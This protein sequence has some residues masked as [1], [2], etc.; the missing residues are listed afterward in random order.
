MIN[1]LS[2][3]I[4]FTTPK[5]LTPFSA[6]HEHIPFAF[7]IVDLLRPQVIVELGTAHGDSYCAF[8]Q[9]VKEL[10]LKTRCYAVDTW[11]GDPHTG[12]YGPEVL[13]DLRAHHDPLYGTFSQ[14]VQSTFDEALERFPNGSIDL[15]HIDGYHVY[16][17]VKH[18]FQMWLPKLSTRGVVLLHDTNVKERGFGVKQLW[19]EVKTQYPSFEFFH[20]CGLGVLAIGKEQPKSLQEFLGSAPKEADQLRSLFSVL[21]HRLT[22][23]VR[24][25]RLE[26]HLRQQE[27]YI[28]A[29]LKQRQQNCRV[30]SIIP[31]QLCKEDR[32]S[33]GNAKPE[34]LTRV[35]QRSVRIPDQ[36]LVSIV[37]P[38]YNQ[39]ELTRQCLEAIERTVQEVTYEIIVVDNGSSDLTPNE[40]RK[41]AS[42]GR[43][44]AIF[45][46]SN[47]GFGAACNQ[48]ARAARGKYLIFLNNDTIPQPGWLEALVTLAE[49]RVKAGAVGAKLVYPDGRLQEAGGIVFS[50][51]SGWNYGR[52]EDPNDPRFNFVRQVDYCSAAC[53]LVR[54]DL[55]HE[56]GGF[57]T[58]FEPAYYEDT[59]LCFAIRAAGF[60]VYYQPK[61]Q[62]IHIEGATAG[63]D[64]STGFK[65]FQVIN[66]HK[67]VDK[68]RDV[69]QR[70]YPPDRR[71]VR[72]AS[73]RAPGKR[74][75][76]VDAFLPLF[77]RASG[78]RRLFEILKIFVAQGHAVTFIARNGLNQE[79][80]A[81]ELRRLGVEVYST[82]PDKLRAL[83]YSV[84]APPINLERLLV[85]SRYDLAWLSFYYIA[86]QYLPD[87][88]RFSPTTRICIDTGDIHFIREQRQA[89][90]YQ[91]KTLFRK[92]AETRLREID[93]YRQ[94]DAV[95]TVT[96]E[97]RKYLLAELPEARI[98]VVPNIHEVQDDAPPFEQRHGLLFVGNFRHTPNV[99]AVLFF[100][101]E[102]L[103][104]VRRKI[105]EVTFTVVGDAPPPEIQELIKDGI[106]V[107]GY[108]P[109]VLP[110]LRA[111]RVAVAPLR[112]GAGLKGKIGEAL[113][114]GTPVVTTSIGS[115][116]MHFKSEQEVLLVADDPED[117]AAATIRLYSDKAL[118]QRLSHN[119]RAYVKEHYAPEV[120]A[121]RIEAILNSDFDYH[122]Q[123]N[124][125]QPSAQTMPNV[126]VS[127]GFTRRGPFLSVIVPVWKEP[128]ITHR[129]MEAVIRHT[130]KPY[131]IIIIDNASD[132]ET[133]SVIKSV[134]RE[135]S[136]IRIIRNYSN[137][138][139]PLACN[140]GL[141]A[142]SG[143][144]IVVMNNDVV[145]TPHWASRM[146]AAFAIDPSI[147]IVG[148][149]TNYCAGVQIVPECSYDESLLDSWAE[150]WYLRHAG[151]LRPTNRLIGFL[152]MMKREVVEKIG[153]FDPLF[154]I[155]NYEDDDYCIRAQL[156]GYKLV[157]ADDV[158][159]HHYGSRSFK[160]QPDAYVKL[161]QTNKM[162]FAGKWEVDFTG[163]SYRPDQVV[164]R[165]A[166]G[167]DRN[168]LYI[169]L[170][171]NEIFSPHVEPLDVG[172]AASFKILCVPDPS[173]HE[174]SWLRLVRDYLKAFRPDEGVGLVVRVEPS[175]RDWFVKV[176]SAIQE[177]AIKEGIDLDRNDL[178]VEARNIPS[179]QRG[180]VYRAANIFVALPGIRKQALV[181]EAQACGLQIVE[182]SDLAHL[183]PCL[184]V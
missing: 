122:E 5:R 134:A 94:A 180:R 69:L 36:P 184:Q 42:E 64:L 144:Y 167:V 7:F 12:F 25:R 8:C 154:G 172:C 138:G 73:N 54:A 59:D 3:P 38:V 82:D 147:G 18:D 127:R 125:E 119:G 146:M 170:D 6:W 179:N 140:Q 162:L 101:R 17:A 40:L 72:L 152:W 182:P 35:S 159:V 27:G 181:R 133:K 103:P 149:R 160:K 120:V 171:F 15:L 31:G 111:H 158:F 121:K 86:E 80:Y 96:E 169:P 93:I 141:A 44:R 60:E 65:R 75:L 150:Q 39:V 132:S 19:D 10:S 97:D 178:V 52:G 16:E 50:D 163:N 102:I 137:L 100:V 51:G 45:N 43:L 57:D 26:E 166:G 183:R 108:V 157:I 71:W 112:Y 151:T 165:F 177:M 139:Y 131:E 175:S 148:P 77:D 107:T 53:L 109:D 142:A 104:R 11:R 33:G 145:V 130:R 95:I 67:F 92:A 24:C 9:A 55:F 126:P 155:G 37:I 68:W 124:A 114:A 32:T 118:W 1:P 128:V 168:T 21:G 173:D 89:E 58:R 83:G 74:I 2:H 34:A 48:G 153:G 84:S 85:E 99:D 70:Q 176:V 105:P 78:S 56:L 161:L 4:I 20:G 135:D 76:V 113:A 49:E 41:W 23:L 47:V 117:F 91:D 14:L 164:A 28:A 88:R 115:E 63:T 62:V 106:V 29:I 30:V 110:Y 98:H 116:G 136:N 156:A 79:R 87:I 22:L 129:C 123:S 13:A 46:E 81:E 61:A 143:D 90:V 174:H 66:R